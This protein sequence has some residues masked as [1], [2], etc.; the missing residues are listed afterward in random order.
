VGIKGNELADRTAKAAARDH[1]NTTTFNRIPRSTL[2]KETEHETIAKW[3][4]TWEETPKA[5]L[6][7]QFFPNIPTDLK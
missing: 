4:K 2:Y 1:E 6:T 3:Q 5:A 7:K